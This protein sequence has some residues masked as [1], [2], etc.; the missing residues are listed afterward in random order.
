MSVDEET[1][2]YRPVNPPF[3]RPFKEMSKK[4]LR[5]YFEWF[6]SSISE[7]MKELTAEV[8]RTVGYEHWEPD[9]SP[10]SLDTLGTWY[11]SQVEQRPL[12]AEEMAEAR[13]ALPEK[14]SF[15]EAE[16]PTAT[17]TYR[18][19][20]LAF[21]IGVYLSQVLLRNCDALSWQQVT[22]GKTYNDYGQPVLV[23]LERRRCSP[24]LLSVVLAEG[25]AE[26]TKTAESLCEL[27]D[28]WS[29]KTLLKVLELACGAA[30]RP[31]RVFRVRS[32]LCFS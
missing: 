18:S 32:S 14:Y 2:F 31:R 10:T 4:E 16:L 1:V 17:L 3:E 26:G 29:R 7:R 28:I 12:T 11:A 21:D 27:Y 6:L 8:R 19:L 9:C 22:S 5:A 13:A 23:G 20:S 24:L 15:L 25:L 30:R